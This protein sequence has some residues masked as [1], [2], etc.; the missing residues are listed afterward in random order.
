MASVL[1]RS[2]AMINGIASSY[3]SSCESSRMRRTPLAPRVAPPAPEGIDVVD[4]MGRDDADINLLIT[5]K[6]LE[7]LCKASVADLLTSL[8]NMALSRLGGGGVHD[9][10][11]VGSRGAMIH[12]AIH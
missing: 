9:I 6:H 5:R 3:S 2:S 4:N 10:D 12:N 8:I 1:P 11:A 7:R